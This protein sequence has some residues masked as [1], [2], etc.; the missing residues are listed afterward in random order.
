MSCTPYIDRTPS[1]VDSVHE[2]GTGVANQGNDFVASVLKYRNE[3]FGQKN[4]SL[5]PRIGEG[6]GNTL[7][8]LRSSY[9]PAQ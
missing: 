3:A 6:G 2:A 1:S 7:P 9:L 4:N 5:S 8:R